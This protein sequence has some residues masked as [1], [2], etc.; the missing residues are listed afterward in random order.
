MR[1]EI[2]GLRYWH[3]LSG[4][5][6]WGKWAGRYKQVLSSVAKKDVAKRNYP[7][8]LE[9]MTWVYREFGHPIKEEIEGGMGCPP[10]KY[11]L[12]AA[13]TLG[14]FFLLSIGEL[15]NLRMRDVRIEVEEGKLYLA[16]FLGGGKT[17]QYNQGEFKRLEEVGGLLCPL[18]ALVRYFKTISWGPSSNRKLFSPGTRERLASMM[19]TAASVNRIDPSRIGAHSL[20]SGGAN[21]MFVAGYDSEAIKR[22][23][24]GKSDTF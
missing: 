6:D 21:A 10:S 18:A 20:R 9:L 3:L 24:R 5:P 1:T 16:L 11:E 17:D 15:G 13:M 12:C 4:F 7:F 2:S 14:F 22:W 23:G 8:N 19:K